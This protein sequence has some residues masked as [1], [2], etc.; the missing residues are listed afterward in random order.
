VN[1]LLTVTSWRAP[2]T[3]AVLEA[4]EAGPWAKPPPGRVGTEIVLF[5]VW[6][7]IVGCPMVH[8]AC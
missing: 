3:R 5:G 1:T 4:S 7:V 2:E 6:I 8:G